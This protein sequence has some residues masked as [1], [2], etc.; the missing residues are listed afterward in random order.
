MIFFLTWWWI[1]L[2][3][4]VKHS[5][6]I[7]PVLIW[8]QSSSVAFI[9]MVLSV[10]LTWYYTWALWNFDPMLVCAHLLPVCV[11]WMALDLLLYPWT[12][13]LCDTHLP[14]K[15]FGV[16]EEP[17]LGASSGCPSCLDCGIAWLYCSPPSLWLWW[18]MYVRWWSK[19]LYGVVVL[20]GAS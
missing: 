20:Y 13:Y 15:P 3:W 5:A 10:P 12:R 19:D 8:I 2:S 7:A 18:N 11:V 1:L 17:W 9:C 14:G 16:P 4:K 6:W